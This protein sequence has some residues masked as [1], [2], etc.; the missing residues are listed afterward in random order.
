MFTKQEHKIVAEHQELKKKE[1][2][3]VQTT[4]SLNKK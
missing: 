1:L 3:E 2:L 4:S